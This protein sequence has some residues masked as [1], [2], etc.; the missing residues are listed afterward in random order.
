MFIVLIICFICLLF[1]Q[2]FKG[3]LT[4]WGHLLLAQMVQIMY[5][6]LGLVAL[7]QM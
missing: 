3:R 6:G 2:L 1:N 4:G 7:P 5:R